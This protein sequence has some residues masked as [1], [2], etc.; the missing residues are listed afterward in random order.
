MLEWP[1]H[2]WNT[3]QWRGRLY[4]EIIGPYLSRWKTSILPFRLKADET[5]KVFFQPRYLLLTLRALA[6]SFLVWSARQL[7]LLSG[8]SST[9]LVFVFV[10]ALQVCPTRNKGRKTSSLAVG[11]RNNK[12]QLV[13]YRFPFTSQSMTISVTDTPLQSSFSLMPFAWLSDSDHFS[14]SVAI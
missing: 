12:F 11:S 9:S 1:S 14:S 6:S 5:W 2:N 4:Q 7:R 10:L 13:V 8:I 3:L